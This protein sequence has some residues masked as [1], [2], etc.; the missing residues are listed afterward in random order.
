M[1]RLAWLLPAVL[2]PLAGCG[3]GPDTPEQAAQALPYPPRAA[4]PAASPEVEDTP[5]GRIV[6]VGP[7]PEGVAVDPET[8]LVAVGVH[9]PPRLVL[10]DA[11]TGAVRQEVPL[12][13]PPRHLA[14]KAP[15]GPVLVPAEEADRLVEVSLPEGRTRATDV[16]DH[17]HD[18]AAVG[19]R[20]AVGDE[21]GS[22]LTVAR[23]G[24]VEAQVPVDVQPGGVVAVDDRQVAVISVRA[25]TV[26]L[27]DVRRPQG[28]GSQSAG[29]GPTH[30]VVDA[31]GRLYI[32][33]TRGDQVI[34]F[35]TRPRLK[36]I[37]R[38]PLEGS[39]YGIAADPD[40]GRVWVT[41]TARNEVTELVA[42]PKPRR[43]RTLDTVRQPNT[44][45]VDP[46]DGRLFIASRT[47]GTLQILDP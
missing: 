5:P 7:K 32:T 47:D 39:P 10:L 17:P 24:R 11:G 27:F 38:V 25:Y 37:A 42:G 31:G 12:P 8:G 18:V 20:I 29:V 15:G 33:D 23:G 22:T 9:D 34:V 30:A 43:R 14:L 45:A 1:R 2:I 36:W 26:E 21:F 19:D 6:R 44:I 40:R 3:S 35:E 41:L 16:G 13:S 46:R 28:K 4:E